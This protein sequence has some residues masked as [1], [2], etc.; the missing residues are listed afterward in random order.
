MLMKQA[1]QI[2]LVTFDLDNT[3]WDVSQ[4]IVRAEQSLRQWM[5]A[6]TADALT[7]YTSNGIG[8]IRQRVLDQYPDKHHDLSFLRT[9]ILYECMLASGLAKQDAASAAS[10]AFDVFFVGRN[11]VVF[12][13][14]A[15]DVLA[16]LSQR[17]RL[18]ALTNGNANI[19]RVGIGKYFEGAV[20]SA[21]VGASKPDPKMFSAVLSRAG[22]AAHQAVHI[23]DHLSDDILGANNAGM[24]SLWYN[25]NGAFTNDSES[26]PSAEV[27]RLSQLPATIASLMAS[28]HQG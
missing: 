14:G 10:R 17:Y 20:S 16:N 3:L 25:H 7:V 19:D 27:H 23:G 18:F 1:T 15:L 11:E 5:Q 28:L 4:T 26:V 12:Y 24:L 8:D 6:N 2:E 9:Q 21:D 13:D 22:V